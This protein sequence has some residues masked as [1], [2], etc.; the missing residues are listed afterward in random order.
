MILR[1]LNKQKVKRN[2]VCEFFLSVYFYDAVSEI[3]N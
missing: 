2:F 3:I 1:H